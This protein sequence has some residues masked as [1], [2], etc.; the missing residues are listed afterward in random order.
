MDELHVHIVAG[1]HKFSKNS[2]SISKERCQKSDIQEV[3]NLKCRH[4]LDGLANKI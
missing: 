2:E 4:C 1:V 3:H